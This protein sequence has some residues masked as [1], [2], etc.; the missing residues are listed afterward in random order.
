MARSF[1]AYCLNLAPGR[2]NTYISKLNFTHFA[3]ST[4]N[5]STNLIGNV[6][7]GQGHVAGAEEGILGDRHDAMVW[8][9]LATEGL[10][11]AVPWTQ[12]DLSL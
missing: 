4:D 10:P 7:L 2:G 9:V 6:E 8:A 11:R 12:C 1:A 3:Q 5:L